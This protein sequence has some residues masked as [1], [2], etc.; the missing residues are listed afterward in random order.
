MLVKVLALV[1]AVWLCWSAY[2]LVSPESEDELP[3]RVAAGQPDDI[4]L[5]DVLARHLQIPVTTGNRIELLR[6]GDEIFPPMIA[7]IDGAERSVR[8]VSYVW[9]TGDIATRM[10]QR[11]VAAAE[12]GVEVRLILDAWGGRK[13]DA[14]LLDAMNGAGVKV[15]WFH[16]FAW[17]TLR[18]LNQRTHRKILIV[19]DAV[20]FAGGVGIAAEWSGDA[21]DADEWR[22]NHF[23]VS[24]PAVRYLDGSFAENW[25]NATGE[26]LLAD[27]PGEPGDGVVD[28]SAVPTDASAGVGSDRI[29]LLSTS[30]RG[31]ISPIALSYWT[32]LTMASRS[33]DIASPYFVPDRSLARTVID[34]ARRGV[35]VR[36]LLPGDNND[37]LL[38]RLASRSYYPELLEA[39]VQIH[40]FDP[41]MTHTKLVIVDDRWA[42]VG[43]AN[44][45]NRS[46]ELNDEIVM[47]LDAPEMTRRLGDSYDE[48]IARASRILWEERSAT[49]RLVDYA[50]HVLLLLRE[51]L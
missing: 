33:V 39:G 43:S 47:L 12:R 10:A 37:S 26:L 42:L 4:D 44:F 27:D 2:A 50:S 11:L 31:D 18:R 34:T 6:N 40:Q 8:L 1:G 48:D 46:F 9:W 19:D 32:A 7:A 30:P 21:R 23:R 45:D 25:L 38:V 36:L 22:D 5:V 20:A 17:D 49:D 41:T 16:P 51:Q 14:G 35:R 15:A 29:A 13:I 3:Q 28:V 24:G